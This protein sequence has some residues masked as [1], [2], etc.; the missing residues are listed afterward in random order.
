MLVVDRVGQSDWLL[1][2][3]NSTLIVVGRLIFEGED[4]HDVVAASPRCELLSKI[5]SSRHP[6]NR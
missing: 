2:R 5:L 4:E 3:R 1:P 6:V